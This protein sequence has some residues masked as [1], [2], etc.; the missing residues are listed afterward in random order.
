MQDDAI[1]PLGEHLQRRNGIRIVQVAQHDDRRTLGEGRREFTGARRQRRDF[2][3]IVLTQL[4]GPLHDDITRERRPDMQFA[5][6]ATEQADGRDR[7]LGSQADASGHAHR[8]GILAQGLG[9]NAH[10]SRGIEQEIQR[11]LFGLL[12]LLDVQLAEARRD[13]PVDELDGVAGDIRTGLNILQAGAMEHGITLAEV[14][15]VREAPD[16]DFELPA[17]DRIVR[18]G[19]LTKHR[20]SLIPRELMPAPWRSSAP[21]PRPRSSRGPGAGRRPRRDRRDLPG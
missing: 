7:R 14:Q 12:E 19:S 16:G 10:G 6:T 18:Q 1:V 2:S 15:A 11:D 3:E 4:M 5:G 9:G 8:P 21:P 20:L 17:V 13:L